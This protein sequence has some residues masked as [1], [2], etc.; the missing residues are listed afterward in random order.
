M[1]PKISLNKCKISSKKC[2]AQQTLEYVYFKHPTTIFTGFFWVALIQFDSG[3][4][5]NFTTF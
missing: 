2:Y 4:L 1:A 5:L 3:N